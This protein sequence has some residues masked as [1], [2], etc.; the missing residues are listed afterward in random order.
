MII[1]FLLFSALWNSQLNDVNL[2]ALLESNISAACSFQIHLK[3]CI[4]VN[5]HTLGVLVTNYVVH[6]NV[7]FKGIIF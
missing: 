2:F 4:H 1:P 6:Y 7:G 5:D 3:L